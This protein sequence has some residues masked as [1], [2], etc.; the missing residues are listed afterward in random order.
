MINL[1]ETVFEFEINLP[2]SAKIK[3][4]HLSFLLSVLVLVKSIIGF[5]KALVAKNNHHS[6]QHEFL[7][8][9]QVIDRLRSNNQRM[10]IISL[11]S[12]VLWTSAS[13]IRILMKELRS[14]ND[15]KKLSG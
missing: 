7:I 1:G 11:F 10:I 13:K 12:L 9:Q 4:K 14:R 6:G 15:E 2:G 8:R 5:L 3:M